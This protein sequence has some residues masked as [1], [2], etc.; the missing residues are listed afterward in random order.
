MTGVGVARRPDHG[1]EGQARHRHEGNV[2]GQPSRG[3]GES[4]SGGGEQGEQRGAGHDG[5]LQEHGNPVLEAEEFHLATQETE[6]G[7]A[8]ERPAGDEH[9]AEHRP[10]GQQPTRRPEHDEGR[11]QQLAHGRAREQRRLDRVRTVVTG[12]REVDQGAADRRSRQ[13]DQLADGREGN[14]LLVNGK[15]TPVLDAMSGKPQRWRIV[16]VANGRFMRLSVPGQ[17]IYRIGGDAGLIDRPAAVRPVSMVP[18]PADPK[19]RISES[20]PDAGLILVPGERAEVVITPQG[21]L[22][23]E[24]TVEWHDLPR[25]RH[26]VTSEPDG[27]LEYGHN[28]LP[29]LR[30]GAGHPEAEQRLRV[31]LAVDQGMMTFLELRYDRE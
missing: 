23:D 28:G 20:N 9:H 12:R 8:G 4:A 11:P 25:G 17:T 22:G 10:G 27:T 6:P 18:D 30:G 15:V 31:G 26:E 14:H 13:S 16:N 1:R 3:N 29:V 21:E 5:P 19:R 2:E 24:I 7:G